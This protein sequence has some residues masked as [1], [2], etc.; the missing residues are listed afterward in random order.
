VQGGH[1]ASDVVWAGG[2][3]YLTALLLFYIFR[4]DRGIWWA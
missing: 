3:T 2:L 4:F 1:F